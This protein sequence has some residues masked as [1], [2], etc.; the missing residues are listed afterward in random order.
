MIQYLRTMPEELPCRGPTR[1]VRR[2]RR[3]VK[4]FPRENL[5]PSRPHRAVTRES[6]FLRVTFPPREGE[7]ARFLT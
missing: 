5:P 4:T 3:S 6:Y 2:R 7:R 1:R